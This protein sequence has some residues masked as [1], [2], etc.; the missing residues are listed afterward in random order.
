MLTSILG[1]FSGLSSTVFEY[2]CIALV[3]VIVGLSFKIHLDTD[4]I[5]S[6]AKT[7]TS[8]IT[9]IADQKAKN[10]VL[11]SDIAALKNAM[12]EQN[13]SI[14]KLKKDSDQKA[15]DAQVALDAA[16]QKADVLAK[17]NWALRN[18]KFTSATECQDVKD[19][20]KSIE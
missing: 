14:D 12:Q 10:D 11:T 15:A 17:K 5:D 13:D 1:F 6:Q 4:T 16:T 8:Q 19:V 9:M 3:V 7:I 20:F 2:I 18:K